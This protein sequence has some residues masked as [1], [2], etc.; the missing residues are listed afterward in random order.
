MLEITI[1]GAVVAGLAG[2]AVALYNGLVRKRNLVEEAWS[3]I[4]VQLKRRTD[5]IPN[6]VATVKGYAAHEQAT[7]EEV[8]RLRGQ[9]VNTQGVGETAQ[10]QGLLGAAL[11]KLVALAENYPE[12]KANTTFLE[13]QRSLQ[14][15]EEQIQLAR[16]YYN[17]AV[18]DLNIAVESF[19]SNLIAVRF[20]F[21]KAEFFELDNVADRVLPQVN[22]STNSYND[23]HQ[24]SA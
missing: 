17:G 10:A 18:R 14:N 22:F 7:F 13:L 15:I 9:A 2:W 3:G 16:R 20:G 12:L 6:L 8:V 11:G 1:A 5:L 23:D 24:N 4:D 19:P 21:A